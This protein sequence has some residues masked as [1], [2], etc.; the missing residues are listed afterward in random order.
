MSDTDKL[1]QKMQSMKTRIENVKSERSKLEGRLQSLMETLEKE[2][3]CASLQ[4]AER[5][6]EIQANEIRQLEE[7]VQKERQELEQ[8]VSA[9]ENALEQV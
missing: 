3:Q 4:D 6:A 8:K 2:F 5:K 1:V 7:R 9:I